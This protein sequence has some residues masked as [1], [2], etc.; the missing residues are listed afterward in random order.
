MDDALAL[1][2]KARDLG[3]DYDVV[4]AARIRLRNQSF[5]IG[6]AYAVAAGVVLGV[7]ASVSGGTPLQSSPVGLAIGVLVALPVTLI[8]IVLGSVLLSVS[9]VKQWTR[10]R[11][12]VVGAAL[13]CGSAVAL[14]QVA[15]VLV[16][17]DWRGGLA[18]GFVL[19]SSYLGLQ[20][21]M[22]LPSLLRGNHPRLPE[23]VAYYRA[24]PAEFTLL[25]G[26]TEWLVAAFAFGLI[27]AT[28]VALL[29]AASPLTIVAVLPL[30][31]AVAA[32]SAHLTFARGARASMTVTAIAALAFFV[33]GL[34]AAALA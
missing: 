31:A 19:L 4:N 12:Q 26:R 18:S 21:V 14:L 34:L 10:R 13:I 20:G 7:I 1:R 22:Q 25:A 33:A 3:F 24:L 6:L 29:A 23:L 17:G 11:Q 32:W 16:P 2:D 27:E 5:L 9:A 8:P 30:R 28:G 15:L